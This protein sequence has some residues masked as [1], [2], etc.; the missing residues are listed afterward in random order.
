MKTK[1][2]SMLAMLAFANVAAAEQDGFKISGDFATSVFSESGK[3]GTAAANN[4]S[5][6]GSSGAVGLSN[7]DTEFSVDLLELNVEKA[8][9]NSSIVV[10]IGYGRI[11]DGINYTVDSDN[12]A[13]PGAPKSTL[14][15]TNAYFAHKFGDSGFNFRIGKF[16]SF[17]GH[18]TYNY[19]DNMNYSRGYAFQ[20][21]M[22]FYLTGANA[23]YVIN[24]MFDVGLYVANTSNSND[25]DENRSKTMGAQINIKPMEGLAIK[26]NY[27][28]SNDGSN[29]AVGEVD[30]ETMNGIISYNWNQWDFAFQ[31]VNKNQEAKIGGTDTDMNVLGL[32]AGYKHDVWGAG[33]RYEMVSYDAGTQIDNAT[34]VDL[35]TLA[36]PKNDNKIGAITLSAWYDIDQNA[37]LKVDIAQHSSDEKVYLKDD[38][39]SDDSM[40]VYGLG[41][42][43]RF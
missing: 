20:Y 43:Y 27:L 1:I 15:L 5:T 29:T 21:T 37:R 13:A 8:I 9:G 16:E 22:P 40:M 11:F 41:F 12:F 32:Y 33:L 31:Y 42:A 36:T 35:A 26:L 17:M 34:A 14:N 38:G 7:N 18:E 6:P 24:E 23:N 28:T 2:V 3:G 10:G 4:G 25:V 30:A 19:M 39:T